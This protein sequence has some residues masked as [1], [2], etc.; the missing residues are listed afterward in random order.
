[1]HCL[2]LETE[3]LE[4]ERGLY[5]S[6]ASAAWALKLSCHS[7]AVNS[8]PSRLSDSQ[9]VFKPSGYPVAGRSDGLDA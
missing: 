5:F 3:A 8:D 6:V 2:E 7:L 9:A 4:R 1:M